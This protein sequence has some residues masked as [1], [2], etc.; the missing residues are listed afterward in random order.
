MFPESTVMLWF[1]ELSPLQNNGAR[2]RT[3]YGP[4]R[5]IVHTSKFEQLERR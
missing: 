3:Y 4:L 1:P 5:K 2:S